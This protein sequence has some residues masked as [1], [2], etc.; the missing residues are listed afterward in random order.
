[1]KQQPVVRVMHEAFRNDSDQSVFDFQHGFAWRQIRT[2]RDPEDMGIDCHR[3]L[4]KGCVQ[5]D[6]GGFATDTGE[7]LERSTVG[8]HFAMMFLQ[9]Y[10]RHFH[11]IA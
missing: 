7:C 5:Y 2:V 3:I 10:F 1:M 8:R 9:Q 6:I 4:A 11:D